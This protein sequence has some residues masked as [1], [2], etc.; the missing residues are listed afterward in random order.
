MRV[1]IA[2]TQCYRK[3]VFKKLKNL[4]TFSDGTHALS[5]PYC[6]SW[7]LASQKKDGNANG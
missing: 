3:I 1:V 2:C 5:C 6:G 4:K 7:H